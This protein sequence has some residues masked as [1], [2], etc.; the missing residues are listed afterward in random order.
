M[1]YICRWLMVIFLSLCALIFVMSVFYDDSNADYYNEIKWGKYN[2]AI[3]VHDKQI[4]TLIGLW[5]NKTRIIDL[6]TLG[7]MECW[8]YTWECKNWTSDIWHM[9]INQIHKIQYKHSLKLYNKK[10]WAELY[11]YQIQYANW[12]LDGYNKWYCSQEAFDII[13]KERTTKERFKCF[14]RS[15]N[16]SDK[17]KSYANLAWEKRKQIRKYILTYLEW[18]K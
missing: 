11:L 13:W 15:Y 12:L 9:Q 18:K 3:T 5:Y 17:K 1:N 10:K 6:I 14:A 16:W 7:A 8:K 4:D 2:Q